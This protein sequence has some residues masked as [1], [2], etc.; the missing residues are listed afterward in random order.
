MANTDGG[1]ILYGVE[2]RRDDSANDSGIPSALPG[3]S[4]INLEQERLRLAAMLQDGVSPPLRGSVVFKEVHVSGSSAAVLLLGI[5]RSLLA[6]HRVTYER[7]NKFWR[8]SESGKY[9][10]DVTELRRLFLQADSWGT[11]IDNFRRARAEQ[12]RRRRM[13]E[14]DVYSSVFIHVLPLGRLD[15]LLDLR[16]H[17]QK[18]ATTLAP[19]QQQGWGNRYN[20][21]GFMTYTDRVPIPS[22]T[23]WFR[24]GGIEGYT[25]QFVVPRSEGPPIF[26]ARNLSITIENYVREALTAL[27]DVLEQEPPYGVGVSLFGIN[28]AVI[29]LHDASQSRPVD[30]DEMILPLLILEDFEPARLRDRL[31]PLIDTIWQAGGLPGEPV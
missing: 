23:Q 9:E 17:H 13:P 15:Q 28:G 12:I 6:P 14:V 18:L 25:S 20:V 8:R 1:C 24:F 27:Q 10:P 26:Q 21:D 7:S 2:T 5:P 22:Y 11:E 4:G 3:I 30:Q 29:P 16:P 19:P 31:R